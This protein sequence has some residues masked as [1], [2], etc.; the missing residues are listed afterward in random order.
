M[1]ALYFDEHGDVDVLRYGDFPDP[2]VPPGWVKLKVR[3]CALNYLDVFARRGMPGIKVELPGIT[4]GDCVGDI[5]ELGDGVD[6]WQV[7]QRVLVYPPHVDFR[8]GRFELM[9]E[10]RRGA[11]ADYCVARASQLMAVSDHVADDDAA[12]LPCAYGTAYRMMFTRGGVGPD[13]KVL[14]LG[15][16]GGV[17]NAALLF[18]KHAGA[19]VVAAAGSAEK[20]AKLREIGADETIDYHAVDFVDYTR[21]TTGSLLRGG[22]YDVVVNFTGGDSWAKSIRCVK[23]HGRLL[24]CGGTA[25]YFPPTDIRY[26]FTA[27]MDIRGSTGWLFEE[28]QAVLDLVADGSIRPV[29]GAVYPLEDGKEA[30]RALEDRNF[31]G[32]II[33]K[34]I[35]KP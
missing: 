1:K 34:P 8:N 9:G 28:Q 21:E 5:V 7:G 3:A 20:C 13:D 23:R 25:G 30:V 31:F 6:G 19:H 11:L 16:S 17:G 35:V 22:G 2:E 15:A 24:T 12:A 27:E 10:T 18:A 29:I 14:V 32:K 4:G 26:I 33:V